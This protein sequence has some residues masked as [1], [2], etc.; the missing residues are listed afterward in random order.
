MISEEKPLSNVS[1]NK[2]QPMQEGSLIPNIKYNSN[3]FNAVKNNFDPKITIDQAQAESYRDKTFY[4]GNFQKANN[5]NNVK[6]HPL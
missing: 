6:D 5:I 1:R 2:E 4:N 3:T